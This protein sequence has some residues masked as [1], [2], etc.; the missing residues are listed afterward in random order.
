MG[1]EHRDLP[2]LIVTES[3]IGPDAMGQGSSHALIES[4]GGGAPAF[5][6]VPKEGGFE[7]CVWGARDVYEVVAGPGHQGRV[8]REVHR[9]QQRSSVAIIIIGEKR[10]EERYLELMKGGEAEEEEEGRGP[11]LRREQRRQSTRG[12]AA[13]G[14]AVGRRQRDGRGEVVGMSTSSRR[15]TMLGPASVHWSSIMIVYDVAGAVNGG[16]E[17]SVILSLSIRWPWSQSSAFLLCCLGCREMT[18]SRGHF[19]VSP[20]IL[21]TATHT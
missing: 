17:F 10:G 16:C 14:V 12:A 1:F 8:G 11:S 4:F 3:R 6:Y 15:V 7:R 2:I 18:L 21:M 13:R 19:V 5:G 20:D 9:R